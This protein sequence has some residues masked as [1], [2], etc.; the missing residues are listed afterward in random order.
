MQL[1]PVLDL[2]DGIVVHA[3]GGRRDEYLPL[4]SSLA[5]DPS[6]LRVV[7]GLLQWHR[8]P[9]LYI[10]DL[11]AIRGYGDNSAVIAAIAQ[12]Y[13]D[14]ELWIDAGAAS[15]AAIARLFALGVARPVIGTETLPDLAAW[16]VLRTL[17]GAER[18]VLSLD[19]RRGDFLGP[20][21]LDQQPELWSETVIAMSLAQI[22]SR[23]GPDWG[24]L[25]RLRQKRPQTGVFLA[26]GGVRGL[27][28]LRRLAAWGVK[29]VLLAS[30][31]HEGG[32]KPVE[33]H[34]IL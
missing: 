9:Q 4:V 3:R 22:G 2:W 28:D 11:N 24:L 20:V 19:Y 25:E 18:L 27:E 10:A 5:P 7:A 14:L 34:Q 33:L 17:P 13:P 16:Q 23:E 12:N 15:H 26:A 30:A 31:L 29:G 21:G 6:P 32:L 8:F 1:F